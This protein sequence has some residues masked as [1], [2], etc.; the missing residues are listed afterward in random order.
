VKGRWL[1]PS[2]T[3][4]TETICRRV[5]IPNDVEWIAIVNGALTRLG[6][7]DMYEAFGAVTPDEIAERMRVL[8]EEYLEYCP[9]ESMNGLILLEDVRGSGV[10]GGDFTSGAKRTRTV[11]TEVIDSENRCSI[12]SNQITLL[13][14]TYRFDV[15]AIVNACGSHQLYLQ[16]I[17][18]TTTPITG[19]MGF[20]SPFTGGPLG[21]VAIL[22]GEI[23]I[24]AT[25]TF[26]LQHQCS[27]TQSSWGMGLTGGFGTNKYLTCAI[28][29][30]A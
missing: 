7:V 13:A 11:N 14:G 18:D 3:A 27:N 4:P 24:A 6:E 26:E 28:E 30:L 10:N 1:T 29:V 21:D 8:F 23:T 17:T 9:E 12:A 20:A 25:K 2:N 5:L 15:K 22:Q 19:L 16:N